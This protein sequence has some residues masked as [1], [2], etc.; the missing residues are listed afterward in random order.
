MEIVLQNSLLKRL[1]KAPDN[2]LIE[3]GHPDHLW[4]R[5]CPSIF[6]ALY[7]VGSIVHMT[8]FCDQVCAD[9]YLYQLLGW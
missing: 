9:L 7:E 3:V 2:A 1:N 4:C 8:Y 5:W 6:R